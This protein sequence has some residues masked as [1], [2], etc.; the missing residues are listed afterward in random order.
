[1]LVLGLACTI[2]LGAVGCNKTA[3]KDKDKDK[4]KKTAT[5]TKSISVTAPDPVKLKQ[6]ADA[7]EVTITIARTKTDKDVVV[8][9]TD[10]PTGVTADP[11]KITIKAADTKG[12]TKLKAAADA[13]VVS[14]KVAKINATSDDLKASA[15]LKVSVTAK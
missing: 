13:A 5:D 7:T 3:D 1:M 2:G 10:L 15:D 9:I 12:T 14:D 11:A 6:G 4:D 8:E